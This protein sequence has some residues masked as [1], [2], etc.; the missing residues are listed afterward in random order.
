MRDRS[1]SDTIILY[2][3]PSKNNQIERKNSNRRENQ[4]TSVK[5]SK[6]EFPWNRNY[7]FNKLIEKKAQNYI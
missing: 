6:Q 2:F 5:K 4:I 7:Y 1:T 3:S